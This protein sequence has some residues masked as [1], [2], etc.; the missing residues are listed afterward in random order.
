MEKYGF[1]LNFYE[2]NKFD[3][4][5]GIVAPRVDSGTQLV[6]GLGSKVSKYGKYAYSLRGAG[7]MST[8]T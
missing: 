5:F 1:L 6:A 2:G 3:F 8:W 7:E 4:W